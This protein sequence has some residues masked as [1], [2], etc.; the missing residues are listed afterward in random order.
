MLVCK[1]IGFGAPISSF[2]QGDAL[3]LSNEVNT[4]SKR[5]FKVVV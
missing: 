5:F 3:H 1:G 4:A 2:V